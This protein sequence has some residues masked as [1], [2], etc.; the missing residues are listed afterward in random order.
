MKYAFLL[1]LSM[2]TLRL[3]ALLYTML[4]LS[5][6]FSFVSC[7]SGSGDSK[8]DEE[9]IVVTPIDIKFMACVLQSQ[10]DFLD[11][12]VTINCTSSDNK[13]TEKT[14]KLSEMTEVKDASTVSGCTVYSSASSAVKAFAES[15]GD[16]PMRT[17]VYDMGQITSG[18]YTISRINFTV[19]ENRPSASKFSI[20]NAVGVYTTSTMY[21]GV[22]N[23]DT[24]IYAGLKTDEDALK[25]I[26]S[27]GYPSG[28]K[29]SY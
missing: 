9:V 27:E 14:I 4:L 10:T 1:A 22:A 2:A 8:D 6:S 29:F 5:A 24:Q 16:D 15:I 28:S 21:K 26:C 19:K 7:S 18:T 3:S 23:V 11:M 13:T 17:F 12:S 20:L 25:E